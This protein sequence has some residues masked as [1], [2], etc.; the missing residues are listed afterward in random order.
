M[1]SNT[2]AILALL[3]L[4]VGHVAAGV[5]YALLLTSSLQDNEK[6]AKTIFWV[7]CVSTIS[8]VALI[9]TALLSM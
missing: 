2:L 6:V 1:D 8:Y 9:G 3:C 7:S 4:L 5:G